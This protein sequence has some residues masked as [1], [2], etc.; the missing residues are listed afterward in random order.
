M[1]LDQ[2][3][4]VFN[5]RLSFDLGSDKQRVHQAFRASPAH[6][7]EAE[8]ASRYLS[9]K[10]ENFLKR[11]DHV[12][13]EW[14]GVHSSGRSSS[15]ISMIENERSLKGRAARSRSVT[16]IMIKGLQMVKDMPPT[17]RSNSVS[18]NLSRATSQ[19]TLTDGFDEVHIN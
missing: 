14:K 4:T 18:R 12:M 8:T 2:S 15:V 16:N 17:V 10:I 13:E 7:D 6:S 1:S 11:T 19:D 5:G 3:P 9:S